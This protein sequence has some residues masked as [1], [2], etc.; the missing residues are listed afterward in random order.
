MRCPFFREE[1]P[2]PKAACSEVM[3]FPGGEWE[4]FLQPKGGWQQG[5]AQFSCTQPGVHPDQTER[6]ELNSREV[7][8]QAQSFGGTSLVLLFTED[9]GRLPVRA[10]TGESKGEQE[11]EGPTST[12]R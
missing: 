9:S 11:S 5:Q 8:T 3:H 1:D 7:K 10:K 2:S 6:G 12:Q 4:W